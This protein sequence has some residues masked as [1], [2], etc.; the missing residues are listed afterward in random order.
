M[1]RAPEAR[2]VQPP[3]AVLSRSPPRLRGKVGA[4]EALVVAAVVWASLLL[5]SYWAAV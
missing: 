4:A 1:Y 2:V 5:P 3:L